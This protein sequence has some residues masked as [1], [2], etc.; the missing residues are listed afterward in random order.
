MG[1][2]LIKVFTFMLV[3]VVIFLWVGYTVTAITAGQK[4]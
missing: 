3:L 1:K 2:A 4:K